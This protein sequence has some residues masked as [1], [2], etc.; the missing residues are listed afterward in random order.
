MKIGLLICFLA[1][2]LCFL[3]SQNNVGIGTAI[4]NPT[5]LLE[6]QA[7]DKGLLVPRMSAL[8]RLAIVNP[9]NGLM[10]YDTDSACFFLL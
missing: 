10:V 7:N 6:L 5:S 4:P 9:A 3:F 1:F 2:P 8:Q